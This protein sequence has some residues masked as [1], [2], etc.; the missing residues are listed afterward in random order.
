MIIQLPGALLRFTNYQ[1]E[2]QYDSKTLKTG[3]D[4]LMA[5]NPALKSALLD[6]K[7]KIRSAHLL[8]IN[9]DQLDRGSSTDRALGPHDCV[10]IV[11]A[12]AGG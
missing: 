11:T 3:L 7:G 4:S 6:R 12:I 5:Q 2:F 8:F 10:E 1:R 9:G